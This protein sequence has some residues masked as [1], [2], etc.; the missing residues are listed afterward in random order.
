MTSS[1][2]EDLVQLCLDGATFRAQTGNPDAYKAPGD[3]LRSLMPCMRGVEA[4]NL[5]AAINTLAA[6]PAPAAGTNGAT[7]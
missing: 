4:I 2:Y 7:P 1:Q 6:S 3:L 5:S